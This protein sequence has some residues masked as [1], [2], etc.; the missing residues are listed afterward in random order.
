[1]YDFLIQRHASGLHLR[2]YDSPVL[3]GTEVDHSASDSPL[4]SSDTFFSDT[5]NIKSVKYLS[6][7]EFQTSLRVSPISDVPVESTDYKK[8]HSIDSSVSR[9]KRTIINIARSCVWEYFVTLTFSPDRVDRTSYSDCFASVS[10]YFNSLRRRFPDCKYLAVPELHKDGVSYHFHALLSGVPSTEF[11]F[12]GHYTHNNP[13][14]KKKPA[15][16]Y[17]CVR[18]LDGFS[19]A[20]VVRDSS[21]CVRYILKYIT[22]ELCVRSFGRHRYIRSHNIEVADPIRIMLSQKAEIVANRVASFAS[23]SKHVLG[24]ISYQVFEIPSSNIPDFVSF[25]K[26]SFFLENFAFLS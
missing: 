5:D 10:A 23:F 26:S 12:S 13:N 25:L 2:F 14:S 6:E 8:Q 9:T 19:T 17:N 18:F 16:V 20:T 3:T 22:K 24:F 21:K 7:S 4:F 11:S 1:M 15:P